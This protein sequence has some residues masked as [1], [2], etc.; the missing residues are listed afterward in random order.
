MRRATTDAAPIEPTPQRV[1]SFVQRRRRTTSF[2]TRVSRSLIPRHS[3]RGRMSVDQ[4]DLE[5]GDDDGLDGQK[6]AMM[7]TPTLASQGSP[8]SPIFMLSIAK[9]GWPMS[10]CFFR[11]LAAFF[12]Y[13]F[14]S[15][16]N[17][18]Y[19]FFFHKPQFFLFQQILVHALDPILSNNRCLRPKDF[20]AV[21]AILFNNSNLNNKWTRKM[22]RKCSE[23]CRG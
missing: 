18:F 17:F 1:V 9:Q 6:Q 15:I 10:L 19:Y 20:P 8:R 13:K 16:F 7:P 11:I 5:A 23:I 3:M 22:R 14:L 12:P 2:K 4:Q 21:R